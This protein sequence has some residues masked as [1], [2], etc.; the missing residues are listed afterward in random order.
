M[1]DIWRSAGRAAND[2]RGSRRRS[3]TYQAAAV[4][5]PAAVAI[6]LCASPLTNSGCTK[7]GLFRDDGITA[8]PDRVALSGRVCAQDTLTADLPTRVV[9][10]A[11][12]ALG[13]LYD[14]FDPG[15][16]RI[17]LLR[18][19]LQSELASDNSAFAVVGFGPDSSRLAPTEGNFTRSLGELI[20]SINLLSIP[21]PCTTDG[22]CRDYVAGLRTAR[23]LIEG[24]LAQTPA[25][26]RVLTQYVVVFLVAG[27]ANPDAPASACCAPDDVDCIDNGD[28]P[29]FQC[30]SQLE[31]DEVGRLEEAVGAGGGLGV[32][33]HVMHLAAEANQTVNDRV[34][35]I[36]EGLAFRVGG[37]YQRF[38]VRTAF[39]AGAFDVLDVR[40]T[41]RAKTLTV[42]NINSKPTFEGLLTDSDSDGL[43]DEEEERQGTDPR[44]YDTDN[45]GIGD[46]V[47]TLVGFD[48]NSEDQPTACELLTPGDDTDLDGL[49]DCE[50]VLLGIEPTLVD[51]DGDG[52]PDP[53]E[54]IGLT[55]Y[56]IPD[57]ELDSDGDGVSNGDE[58]RQRS[59]PR[60]TDTAF[61]LD[62]GYRYEVEDTG[63]ERELFMSPPTQLGE[64]E[65]QSISPDTTPGIGFIHFD[66][67]ARTL[68]WRDGSDGEPG[69]PVEIGE[70]RELTLQSA[71]G[72]P[73]NGSRQIRLRITPGDLPTE[74]TVE[75]VRIL[76]RERQCLNYMVRNV[77]L[78]PTQALAD[79]GERGKNRLLLFFSEAPTDRVTA[80]G[81]V[82]IAE[83]PVVFEPPA[84]RE[85]DVAVIE[86]LDEE[87]VRR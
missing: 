35:S 81:P 26:E 76:F 77:R 38:D 8:Q 21:E 29:S 58:I 64:V 37:T 23:A 52:L 73:E 70:E 80:P 1:S 51:T 15:S 57:A 60:S 33:L 71:S 4:H 75:M 18:S 19:F 22:R 49:T 61:H 31:R 59:D 42:A 67:E 48:P 3:Q 12:R 78:M 86:V 36:M 25:G 6:A 24:D 41:L 30:Q 7:A 46:L 45:D 17:G 44:A 34:E 43:D 84:R 62:F 47:E 66:A 82:R 83:I 72:D 11:D 55:D 16:E 20:N 69:P 56:I 32:K 50:E 13:P 68:A 14:S 2:V 87:F 54:V 10:V 63:V 39:N 74:T 28:Q 9:I 53:L 79:G 65:V 5:L 40:S 27:A 85:P